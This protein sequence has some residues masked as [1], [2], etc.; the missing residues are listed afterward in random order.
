MNWGEKVLSVWPRG[1][2]E[3][4]EVRRGNGVGWKIMPIP[5]KFFWGEKLQ[6]KEMEER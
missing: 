3:V 5:S 6:E 1:Q 4:I 2:R